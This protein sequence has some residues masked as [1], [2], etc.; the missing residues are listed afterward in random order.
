MPET[1]AAPAPVAARIT[2]PG[3]YDAV[4][5]AAYHADPVDPISVSSGILKLISEESA[6]HARLA[7]PRLNPAHQEA[8]EEKFDKGKVAHALLL[9]RRDEVVVVEADDWRTNAAKNQR[10]AAR[11]AGKIPL[12]R[13]HYADCV[14]M[15]ESA[16]R[17][18]S[19]HRDAKGA[20]TEG[21]PEQTLVWVEETDQGDIFCRCRLD[22][23][24]EDGA[25]FYDHKTT[26]ASANPLH[27]GARTLFD[28]GAHIQA[29]LYRRGISKLLRVKNPTFRFVVQENYSPYAL[30]V[31]ELT[32]QAMEISEDVV[33]RALDYWAWCLE[34]NRWPGY[35]AST[36]YVDL[37]VWKDREYIARQTMLQNFGDGGIDPYEFGLDFWKPIAKVE[38]PK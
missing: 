11:M 32:Q 31:V 34:H 6:A 28:T 12:L 9:E 36:A 37:P 8:E 38:A 29:A 3:I 21:K 16:R 18:L 17:Q 7:H 22:W 35:A 20:F 15:E 1:S 25:I 30:S 23:L 13:K 10:D 24:P 4:P 33:Q 19:V 5:E 2:K 26:G 14:A 27:W